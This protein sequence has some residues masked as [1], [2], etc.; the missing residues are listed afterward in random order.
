MV[1][2]AIEFGNGIEPSLTERLTSTNPLDPEPRPLYG[3][4]DLDGLVGVPRTTRME[5]AVR[6]EKGGQHSLV[7][8]DQPKHHDGDGVASR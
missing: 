7:G 4:M 5:A 2:A 8:A 3:P 1:G 6:T